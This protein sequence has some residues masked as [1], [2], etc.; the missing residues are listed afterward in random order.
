MDD[1]Y[2]NLIEPMFREESVRTYLMTFLSRRM[3]GCVHDKQWAILTGKRNSGKS[4]LAHM[5]RNAFPGYIGDFNATDL[6]ASE[7]SGDSA[8]GLNWF[9]NLEFSR[10][11][12]TSENDN[13]SKP[14]SGDL[15][16]RLTSGS[17]PF[18]ARKLYAESRS[19]KWI[20]T[21]FVMANDMPKVNVLDAMDT[22]VKFSVK[23][24]Y[25]DV[26]GEREQA[27]NANPDRSFEFRVKKPEIT[28]YAKR[29]DVQNAFCNLLFEA[30]ADAAPPVPEELTCN[31]DPETQDPMPLAV[32]TAFSFPP[33]S[34]KDKGAAAH[35]ASMTAIKTHLKQFL[36]PDWV[37]VHGLP[38]ASKLTLLLEAEGAHFK[39]NRLR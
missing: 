18:T 30:F 27:V 4:I 36:E 12:I 3:A 31:V 23:V 1:V 38:T 15:I 24:E 9:C 25:V 26:L 11:A 29:E 39:K 37:K 10:L 35:W 8:K 13:P 33:V 20:G 32:R 21:I 16:K 28:A 19:I 6:Q 14:F 2:N 7:S 34:K 17:D 22:A 5:L